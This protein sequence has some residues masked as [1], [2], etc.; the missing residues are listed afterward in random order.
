MTTFIQA[1]ERGPEFA[2]RYSVRFLDCRGSGYEYA[3]SDNA[4][5]PDGACLYVDEVSPQTRIG[6]GTQSRSLT[7]QREHWFRSFTRC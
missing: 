1:Y 2:D 7:C 3:M 4:N 5:V 6:P